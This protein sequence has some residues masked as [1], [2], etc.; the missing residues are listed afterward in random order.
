M[1]RM[2]R[3]ATAEIRRFVNEHSVHGLNVV[4]DEARNTVEDGWQLTVPGAVRVNAVG[5]KISA[6]AGRKYENSVGS[7]IKS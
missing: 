7:S 6:S 3:G 1:Q 2:P 4:A 5:D